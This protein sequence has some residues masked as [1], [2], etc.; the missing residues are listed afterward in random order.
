MAESDID[1][2]PELRALCE[3][4]VERARAAGAGEAEALAQRSRD[5]SVSVVNGE[6]EQL[7]EAASKGV[8]LRVIR[9]G[10]L[11]FASTTDFSPEALDRLVRRA[12]ELAAASEPDAVNR[13]PGRAE[14][15]PGRRPRV[16]RLFDPA[17]AALDPG[18]KLH[19][20]LEA[21]RAARAEDARCSRF[22]DTGAGDNLSEW[23]IASSHGLVDSE[24]ATHVWVW[25]SPVAQDGASLQTGSWSDSRR[26]LHELESPESIGRE[27]AR[28]TVRMLGA[29]QPPGGRYPVVFEPSMAAGFFGSIAGACNGELVHKRSSFLGELRGQPVASPLVTLAD[30]PR[31]PGAPGAAAFDAEGVPT[32]RLPLLERGVLQNFLYDMRTALKAGARTTGSARRGY[33]SLPSVGPRQ[34]VVEPGQGDLASIVR[35]VRRG[36]LVT[37]L[38]GSGANVV[39]G[40]Y[41]RGANGLWIEDGELAWPVQE[42]TVAGRLL[43]M[44]QGIDAVGADLQR[45]GGTW[46][47]TIRF[48]ELSLAGR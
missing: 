11:G 32:R 39:T 31:I 18:W 2:T 3:Q 7:S 8:G 33:A 22:Q 47:P 29:R 13:L 27:A 23:A 36:L 45:R 9:D 28:R 19:A 1:R 17:V 12:L 44:L 43:E 37:S 14:L 24:R 6:I 16:E 35:G 15:T 48:A 20:A 26:H 38:L 42:A 34:L 4:L 40:E 25:C 10:R 46:S 5:A 21:E 30:D 41:S